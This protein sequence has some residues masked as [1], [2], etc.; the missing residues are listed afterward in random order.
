MIDEQELTGAEPRS[1]RWSCCRFVPAAQ[2]DPVY[3]DTSY[4]VIPEAAGH[5]PSTL[6]FQALSQ[7][8]YVAIGQWTPTTASTSCCC[9]PAATA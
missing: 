4:Y 6:L 5:R 9:G 8:G 7:R 2:V 3:L 1:A